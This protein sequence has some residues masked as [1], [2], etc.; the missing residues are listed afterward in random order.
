MIKHSS[1]S[2][3]SR[4]ADAKYVCPGTGEAAGRYAENDDSLFIL[5]VMHLRRA[6]NYWVQRTADIG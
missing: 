2:C 5:A 1:N 3:K 6:P 4:R